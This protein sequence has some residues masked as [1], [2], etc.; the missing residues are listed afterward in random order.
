MN[1]SFKLTQCFL[2]HA[3]NTM[4]VFQN[5]SEDHIGEGDITSMVE[6]I[7]L[8]IIVLFYYFILLTSMHLS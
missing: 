5:P 1:L 8:Y 4:P 6:T 2:H 3:L 7:V